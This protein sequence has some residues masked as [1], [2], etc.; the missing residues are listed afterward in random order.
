[1]QQAKLLIQV[2][3]QS[4]INGVT[5]IS[6]IDDKA[7]IKGTCHKDNINIFLARVCIRVRACACVHVRAP[8]ECCFTSK[9]TVGL[10][11]TGSSGRPPRLSRGSWTL[12]WFELSDIIACFEYPPKRCTYTC[13]ALFGCYMAGVTWNCC[14]VVTWLV[15]RETAA[16]LLQGW[17]HVKLLPGCYMA[18]ATWKT[19]AV[20]ARCVYTIHHVT[21]LHAKP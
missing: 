9:E 13:T 19:A 15:S 20:S 17:C 16:W 7:N 14:L 11:G 18:G 10:L 21:S 1:M 8:G 4:Y 5:N 2:R 3:P 12:K 6:L